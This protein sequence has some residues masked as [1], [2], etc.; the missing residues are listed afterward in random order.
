M[1]FV[2]YSLLFTV[3]LPSIYK[4]IQTDRHCDP[5]HRTCQNL[6]RCMP[7]KLFKAL[8][9]QKFIRG[10]EYLYELI[11]NNRMFSRLSSNAQGVP[12]GD[13]GEYHCDRKDR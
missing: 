7:D 6:H 13:K 11:E 9:R 1:I 8:F 4:K 3:T 12:H 5:P 10:I 2:L